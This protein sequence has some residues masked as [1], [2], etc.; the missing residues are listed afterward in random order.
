MSTG[1][2]YPLEGRPLTRQL[3]SELIGSFRD[4]HGCEPV[5]VRANP[6]TKRGESLPNTVEGVPL[7][8]NGSVFPDEV[9]LVEEF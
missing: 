3:I 6:M 7:L 1:K 2:S 4:S 5:A 9:L 8:S